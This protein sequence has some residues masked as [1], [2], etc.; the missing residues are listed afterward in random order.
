MK[1][2]FT[3]LELLAV[4]T[5]L[6]IA[7]L[8]TIF[9]VAAIARS[10][11]QATAANAVRSA[12]GIARADAMRT[13]DVHA[14]VMHA[15]HLSIVRAG[16]AGYP[17]VDAAG[18][19]IAVM[20]AVETRAFDLPESFL[21]AQPDYAGD[22][23]ATWRVGDGIGVAFAPDGSTVTPALWFDEDGDGVRQ[24]TEPR[25]RF[26]PM[27]CVVDERDRA[28]REMPLSAWCDE[29]GTRLTVNRY[30]G[31]VNR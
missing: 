8:V 9:S 26:A 19:P 3:I 20:Q 14:V 6:S 15:G 29:F 4:L 24:P 17:D 31:L 27:V 18:L 7:S 25:I 10:S 16:D 2:A 21:L 23:D 11:R 13:G 30:T 1:R 5:I 28:M 22:A 12:L